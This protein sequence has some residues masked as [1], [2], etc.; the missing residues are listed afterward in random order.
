M[1]PNYDSYIFSTPLS[2]G[3]LTHCGEDF[4]VKLPIRRASMKLC[5]T[6]P[7]NPTFGQEEKPDVCPNL[8][9]KLKFRIFGHHLVSTI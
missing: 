2:S 4:S 6:Y 3:N 9:E 7:E 5:G 1:A 8:H